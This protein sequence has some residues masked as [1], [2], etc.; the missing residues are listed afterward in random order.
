MTDVTDYSPEF[1]RLSGLMEDLLYIMDEDENAC[2]H[3]K[4]A[5]SQAFKIVW[6]R[7]PTEF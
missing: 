1:M 2:Q 6:D 3:D 4:D 7:V 5:L